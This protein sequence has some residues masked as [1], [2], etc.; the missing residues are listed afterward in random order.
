MSKK[1][2][3]EVEEIKFQIN[4][5]KNIKKYVIYHKDYKNYYDNDEYFEGQIEDARLFEDLNE[6]KRIIEEDF[7]EEDTEN[8]E[9][10]KIKI[11]YELEEIQERNIVWNIAVG[12]I[13]V[14]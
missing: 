11:T 10:H 4:N 7:D 14:Q 13:E 5:P 2:V 9:I 8:C 12:K 3:S 1:K 6:V